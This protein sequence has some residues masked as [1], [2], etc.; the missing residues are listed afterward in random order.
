MYLCCG[1]I[2]LLIAFVGQLTI[3]IRTHTG[4]KPFGCDFCQKAFTTRTM[5]VKH[6]RIHTG[7]RPY[8]CTICGLSFNQSS[9]L[10]TH[11]L[12]HKKQVLKIAADK[13]NNTKTENMQIFDAIN[14]S[15]INNFDINNLKGN[16]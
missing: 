16:T 5:L 10:K 12:V 7:E 9:T 3:H 11:G 4:E 6:R 14:D 8:N 13:M 1:L 2:E 15:N